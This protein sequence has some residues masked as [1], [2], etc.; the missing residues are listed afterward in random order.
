M[1][2]APASVGL[3]QCAGG[4]RGTEAKI[5]GARLEHRVPTF[6]APATAGRMDKLLDMSLSA[7][8]STFLGGSS[9]AWHSSEA[10]SYRGSKVGIG[11][12]RLS[13]HCVMAFL[14]GSVPLKVP[15]GCSAE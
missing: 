4:G 1:V 6:P 7:S 2:L 14:W 8:V 10:C 9:K 15:G 3:A 5:A 13:L 11:G 12:S